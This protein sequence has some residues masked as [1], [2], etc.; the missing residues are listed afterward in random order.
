[1]SCLLGL[2]SWSSGRG[3]AEATVAGRES[4]KELLG[5]HG[6]SV[7]GKNGPGPRVRLRSV[8][9]LIETNR[10]PPPSF[11]GSHVTSWPNYR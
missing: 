4:M 8:Q 10:T 5:E 6:A 9:T 1:M 3:M 7:A 11:L 2:N